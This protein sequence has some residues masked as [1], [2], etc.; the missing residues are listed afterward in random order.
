[1]VHDDDFQIFLEAHDYVAVY[2]L[3][4]KEY[5]VLTTLRIMFGTTAVWTNLGLSSSLLRTGPL[6][7]CW[8]VK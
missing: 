3:V 4:G 6:L 2:M 5:F 8:R 1:M 7:W